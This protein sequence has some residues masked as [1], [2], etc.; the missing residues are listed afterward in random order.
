MAAASGLFEQLLAEVRQ[1]ETPQLNFDALLGPVG[2]DGNSP[3]AL[4]QMRTAVGRAIDLY[5]DLLG[6]TFALYAETLEQMLG[7]GA[8]ARP[9][10]APA[11]GSPVLITGTPGQ[12]ATATVWLHNVASAPL[13]A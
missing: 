3:A 7:R 2:A 10:S 4:A 12:E 9:G 1:R 6:E 13:T 5:A 8:G 11:V